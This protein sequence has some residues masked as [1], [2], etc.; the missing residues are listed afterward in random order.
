MLR[1]VDQ[2][3][4]TIEAGLRITGIPITTRMTIVRLS[5]G[6]LW[7]HSP[8]RLDAE[9]RQAVE[10]LGGVRSLVA[11]NAFHHL[12]LES[13]AVAWPQAQVYAA[14]GVS[15]KQP[16]VRIHGEL[17]GVPLPQWSADLEQLPVEGMPRFNEVVFLHRS[18]RTLIVSDLVFNLAGKLPWRTGVFARIA[19]I[20]GRLAVSRLFRSFIRDRQA[21]ARSIRAILAWDFDRMIM[22]HGQIV[23]SGGR[24]AL[25]TAFDKFRWF[26]RAAGSLGA[27]GD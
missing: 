21:F 5:S 15:R 26:R 10:A 1:P 4:W 11:P 16:G 7:V 6:G 8:V 19:G 22:A 25:S 23:E 13:A 24:E 27:A 12:F 3:I 18:S 2:D 9:M 14:A 17:T 20:H